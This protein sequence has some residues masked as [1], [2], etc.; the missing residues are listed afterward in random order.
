[1]PK[2]YEALQ[3][4]EQ[5]RRRKVSGVGSPVPAA[6]P[7]EGP[8]APSVSAPRPGAFSR[9]FRRNRGRTTEDASDANKR[10]IALLQPDSY[11]AEQYRSLRG[12]IDALASQRPLKTIA[13]T[14]A[15]SGEGKSTCSVNLATVTAMSVGRS[16]LLIDCDLRRPKIHWTLGLQPQ[17][18]L[19]EVLLNQAT[20]DEAIQKLDGV[21]LDVLMV[22]TIP[23]N[24]SELLAS[25]EMR[26]L[27]EDVAGRYD[28]VILDTPACLGLPDAKGISEI[29]DGLIM[30][31][32]A[33]VTPQEEVQAALDILDRRRVVG[34]V[35]NGSEGTREQYGYY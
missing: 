20:V 27:V 30:V 6:V 18:G 8:I 14:S 28:R 9:L 4:A 7:F 2:H 26:N 22:R 1:M 15:N 35:L 11:V 29:C 32:R 25:P 17:V 3:R 34:T 21:N 5:E 10:R 12:R 23:A 19:A 31:V 16:V 24:P 13:V 33:D